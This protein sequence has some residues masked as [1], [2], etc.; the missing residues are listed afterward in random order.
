MKRISS[1]LIFGAL[2][3]FLPV[4][5]QITIG[6][7]IEPRKGSLLDLKINNNSSHFENADKGLALPRVELSSLTTLTVDVDSKNDDY[8][9]L[10][11][12]N[13]ADN[14]MIR[15]GIYSWDGSQWRHVVSADS[16]GAMDELL[17]SNGDGTYGW[18]SSPVAEYHFHNPTWISEFIPANASEKKFSYSSL[19]AVDYGGGTYGPLS[20]IF[21]GTDNIV[22][23]APFTVKTAAN[24]PKYMLMGIVAR[25]WETVI[26]GLPAQEPF[27]QTVKI[28]ILI[29]NVLKKTYQRMITT[30]MFCIPESFID[31]FSILYVP[32]LNAGQYTLSIQISN[33]RNSFPKNSINGLQVG[34]FDRTETDFYYISLKDMNFVLFEDD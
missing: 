13:I 16:Y 17:S 7:H 19:T 15:E 25:I 10:T 33:I 5:A 4:H 24:Q 30:P 29:N 34:Y 28:D 22:Y 11:V 12:C 20:T 8:V 2:L 14:S 27:W 23:T 21:N 9:G 31:L 32:E 18:I 6:S 26:P 1:S 3:L